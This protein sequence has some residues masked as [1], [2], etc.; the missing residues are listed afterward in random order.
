MTVDEFIA[1]WFGQVGGAE[2]S[3]LAPFVFDLCA[4]LELPTPGIA[5]GGK[6]GDYQFDGTVPRGSFRSTKGTGFIDL[7]KRGCFVLE[8]KQSQVPAGQQPS[9]FE[10]ATDAPQAPSGARYDQLMRDDRASSRVALRRGRLCAA[11]A[12]LTRNLPRS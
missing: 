6:L 7:Y 5:E 9:L 11:D 10:P 1:K 12:S 2:R 8:A 4:A 3:N